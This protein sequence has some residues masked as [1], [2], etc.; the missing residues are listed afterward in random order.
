MRSTESRA[1]VGPEAMR[2]LAD[3]YGKAWNDHDNDAIVA[4]QTEDSVFRLHGAGGVK[5]SVGVEACRETY[6]YLLAAWPDQHFDVRNI[7]VR[8]SFYVCESILTGTLALPWQMG[9]E[10]FQPNGKK[11]GFEIVDIMEIENGRIKTKN[12]WMDGFALREQL[13]A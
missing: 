4:L 12:S 7:V 9:D 3:R 2:E 1:G 6:E 5:E 11:V 10:T 13:R 8:E